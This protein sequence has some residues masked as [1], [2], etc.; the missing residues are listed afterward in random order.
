MLVLLRR[1]AV[2]AAYCY[3]P[4][5]V[6]CRSVCRSVTLVSPAKRMNRSSCR[7]GY[8]LGRVDPGN[9]VF[10]KGA[11]ARTGRSTFTFY[12]ILKI[13]MADGR[14]LDMPPMSSARQPPV[15]FI[16]ARITSFCINCRKL[17]R[18]ASDCLSWF[19]ISQHK[20]SLLPPCSFRWEQDSNSQLPFYQNDFTAASREYFCSG[21][22]IA[23]HL[24][25]D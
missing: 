4:S 8:W 14:C 13:K 7:L 9:Y 18:C 10:D 17:S 15:K 19:L 12:W 23:L 11:D 1:V 20:I 2:T 25:H 24:T 22:P 3:R 6:V 21:R 16:A 5:S